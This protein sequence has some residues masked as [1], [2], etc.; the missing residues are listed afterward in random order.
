M[1]KFKEEDLY[2][3]IDY[4]LAIFG[5]EA[6]ED[7]KYRR[8]IVEVLAQIPEDAREKILEK[9]IF[10]IAGN[11]TGVSIPFYPFEC[12]EEDE[13]REIIKNAK[14]LEYFLKKRL[15]ILN[16]TLMEKAGYT[17]DEMKAVIAHEAAHLVLDHPPAGEWE[18]I[19]READ[20][21]AEKWGFQRTE[22][23]KKGE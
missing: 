21:L 19:Q 5:D 9:G 6:A 3:V 11:I 7:R 18:K 15:I 1:G 14:S 4:E 16:F 22:N 17:E 13:L 12:V 8:L 10:I 2:E 20:D 23:I